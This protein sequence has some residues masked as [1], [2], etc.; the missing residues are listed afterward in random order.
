MTGAHAATA[1]SAATPAA[2]QTMRTILESII[3]FT[4]DFSM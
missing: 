2:L 4:N 1:K 3:P